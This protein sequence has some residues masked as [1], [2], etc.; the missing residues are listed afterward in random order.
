MQ[1][2]HPQKFGEVGTNIGA[3]N[4]GFFQDYGQLIRGLVFA[5]ISIAT[6]I[7]GKRYDFTYIG[8]VTCQKY[9]C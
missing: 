2:V 4:Q 8:T 5:R 3:Q 6:Q 7:T 9:T 1:G